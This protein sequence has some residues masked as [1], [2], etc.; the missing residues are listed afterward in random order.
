MPWPGCL[1]DTID[2]GGEGCCLHATMRQVGDNPAIDQL[3]DRAA[4]G[5]SLDIKTC[6]THAG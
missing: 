1:G 4:A 2:G 3:S 5:F 6:N